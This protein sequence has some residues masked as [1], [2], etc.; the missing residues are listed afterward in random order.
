MIKLGSAFENIHQLIEYLFIVGLHNE[1]EKLSCLAKKRDFFDQIKQEYL[2]EDPSSDESWRK[3]INLS[4]TGKK[5]SLIGKQEYEYLAY[6]AYKL[7]K[8]SKIL[9]IG[10]YHGGTTLALCE[11]SKHN[12][13]Q[14]TSID[15]FVGFYE[16]ARQSQSDCM[17]WNQ[18][19]WQKN[20]RNH[21][22]RIRCISGSAT[23]ILCELAKQGEKFDLIFYDAS[24]GCETPFEMAIMSCVASENC[25]LIAD[26]II[27]FN[28]TMNSSW[29]IGL[30]NLYS[31]PRF[32][33]ALAVANFKKDT[34]PLNL[35][36]DPSTEQ[37]STLSKGILYA[38][39]KK[40]LSLISFDFGC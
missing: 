19:L 34:F 30:K 8:D 21:S 38:C 40:D 10:T 6:S 26:D 3:Q 1:S 17:N 18:N 37:L 39:E 23:A 15:P 11:G 32:K 27:N 9:E 13:S 33:G 22:D 12:E 35:K 5:I 16:G 29:A 4:E 7:K 28:F 20:V 31:F 36:F 24:H 14:I 2:A 25:K